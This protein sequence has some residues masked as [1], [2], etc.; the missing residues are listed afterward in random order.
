[1]KPLPPPFDVPA[2]HVG[3]DIEISDEKY[4]FLF[5]DGKLACLR[6][7]DRWID[8]WKEGAKAVIGLLDEVERGRATGYRVTHGI[9]EGEEIPTHVKLES[10]ARGHL[11]HRLQVHGKWTLETCP[12][13]L[14]VDLEAMTGR[15]KHAK[16]RVEQ[17]LG[18]KKAK[19]EKDGGRL[20]LDDLRRTVEPGIE[21][22]A[23]QLDTFDETIRTLAK[24]GSKQVTLA[25]PGSLRL[26]QRT[27]PVHK[28]ADLF[29]GAV[30]RHYK[31]Q[32]FSVKFHESTSEIDLA[33]VSVWG[34]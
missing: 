21:P 19:D 1:M 20:T 34:W 28:P 13:C 33:K 9:P 7:G 29:M 6:N 10:C 16:R 23:Q 17:F 3:Y 2:E 12:Q 4:R 26:G 18:P 8:E 31:A 14:E 22:T 11:R 30:F 27:E 32:G 5:R 15:A 25:Y 24:A